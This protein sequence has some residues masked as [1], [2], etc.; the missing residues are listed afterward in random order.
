MKTERKLVDHY[1]ILK[2]TTEKP[3]PDIATFVANRAQSVEGVANNGSTLIAA[4]S[5][6]TMVPPVVRIADQLKGSWLENSK[7]DMNGDDLAEMLTSMHTAYVEQ[8]VELD[9]LRQK[10]EAMN[11]PK[12][13]DPLD[14]PLPCDITVGGITL[15]K[16]VKLRTVK[17]RMQALWEKAYPELQN[18]TPESQAEHLR[19]LRGELQTIAPAMQCQGKNCSKVHP[20]DA[21]SP[22]CLAEY[23]AT[24]G[25]PPNDVDL[26]GG[27]AEVW[28][29]G[30]KTFYQA[31]L[32]TKLDKINGEP[33]DSYDD[34]WNAFSELQTWI[35]MLPTFEAT[36]DGGLKAVVQ[37]SVESLQRASALIDARGQLAVTWDIGLKHIVSVTRQDDKGNTLATLAE[38]EGVPGLTMTG[39]QT[40]ST[41]FIQHVPDRCDRIVWR[42]H[43]Y[44]LPLKTQ[45]KAP[46]PT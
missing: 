35:C 1:I 41:H 5:S 39:F 33:I 7:C 2:V 10:L 4:Y 13:K 27:E 8:G 15:S 34:L 3:V 6:N 44:H 30:S 19:A 24:V 37:N 20:E 29:E 31:T 46:C 12:E 43:Y 25:A 45:E 42:E 17:L 21:H 38:G 16:G 32:H 22:E 14:T 11:P 9:A 28:H 18:I 40:H 26:S 36:H 23:D